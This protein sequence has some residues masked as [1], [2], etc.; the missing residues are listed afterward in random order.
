[1]LVSLFTVQ[2]A[3]SPQLSYTTTHSAPLY[4]TVVAKL[5][6]NVFVRSK[7][8][9]CM[10]IRFALNAKES[11]SFC[12]KI[13][14]EKKLF[15]IPCFFFLSLFLSFVLGEGGGSTFLFA[16]QLIA[17]LL[18]Q[19]KCSVLLFFPFRIAE[20]LFSDYEFCMF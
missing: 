9:I 2:N 15:L 14:L 5:H 3:Q 1:M 12:L 18:F 20:D 6:V 19:N 16:F 13:D 17:S 7:L 4:S 10:Q 11:C 8:Q